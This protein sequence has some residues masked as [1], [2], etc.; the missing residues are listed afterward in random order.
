MPIIIEC[1]GLTGE[2]LDK[3]MEYYRPIY[4]RNLPY[5]GNCIKGEDGDI[6]CMKLYGAICKGDPMPPPGAEPRAAGPG[7][8]DKYIKPHC[9]NNAPSEAAAEEQ[10]P[11]KHDNDAEYGFP[12]YVDT[13]KYCGLDRKCEHGPYVIPKWVKDVA[14]FVTVCINPL[15]GLGIDPLYRYISG[16]SAIGEVTGRYD[17]A[18]KAVSSYLDALPNRPR[19]ISFGERHV[20][21]IDREKGVE[22]TSRVFAEEVVS[23]V[24]K[25]YGGCEVVI[26]QLPFMNPA[27]PDELEYFF[28]GKDRT[29]DEKNTPVLWASTLMIDPDLAVILEKARELR[30]EGYDVNVYGGGLTTGDIIALH[31]KVKNAISEDDFWPYMIEVGRNTAVQALML[32]VKKSDKVV[33]TFGGMLHLE[34][35]P[36]SGI[37][38]IAAELGLD[39]IDEIYLPKTLARF[40][41]IDLSRDFAAVDIIDPQQHN[42]MMCVDARNMQMICSG[43]KDAVTMVRLDGD[44]YAHMAMVLPR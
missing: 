21:P 18:D 40:P 6:E 38:E 10:H 44:N 39:R 13:Y 2:H 19:I 28:G 12:S 34:A 30:C 26:E 42:A 14:R 43:R 1:E 17:S 35:G 22:S 4:Q 33:V 23:A 29:I 24:C 16:R 36:D 25:K 9:A 32:A 41:G 5:L 27:V 11:T 20:H 37:S 15:I 31:D 8:Y 7:L 3:C